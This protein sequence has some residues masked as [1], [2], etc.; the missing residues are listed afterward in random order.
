MY[1]KIVKQWD[2]VPKEEAVGQ[3]YTQFHESR[4]YI[5]GYGSTLKRPFVKRMSF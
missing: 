2:M 4:W 5:S 1:D 3:F